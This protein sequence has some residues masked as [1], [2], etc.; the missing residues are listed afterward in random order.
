MGY[1]KPQIIEEIIHTLNQ[2]VHCGDWLND[3]GYVDL[4]VAP[5]LKTVRG[6]YCKNCKTAKQRKDMDEINAKLLKK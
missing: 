2:C 4:S 5:K 6:V 3:K 1:G